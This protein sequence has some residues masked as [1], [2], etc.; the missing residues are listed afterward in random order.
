MRS[1][2][3]LK[4]RSPC[5]MQW[6]YSAQKQAVS[7]ALPDTASVGD[8]Q[9]S[10]N[11]TCALRYAPNEILNFPTEVDYCQNLQV[12]DAG[13]SSQGSAKA[14]WG[15]PIILGGLTSQFKGASVS[16][17]CGNSDS[18]CAR[19]LTISLL[20]YPLRLAKRFDRRLHGRIYLNLAFS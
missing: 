12:H 3:A 4:S 16:S 14:K 15:L 8:M 9:N 11:E 10:L 13:A 19:W 6:S 18:I 7:L 1:A 5:R 20:C 2:Y 17:L